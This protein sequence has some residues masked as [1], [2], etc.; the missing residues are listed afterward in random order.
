MLKI[1]EVSKNEF[2][3]KN[4]RSWDPELI[5]N[6]TISNVELNEIAP[7]K[8]KA[9]EGSSKGSTRAQEGSSKGSTRVQEG[10]SK[11]STRVQQYVDL[12]PAI[13]L[14]TP[15]AEEQTHLENKRKLIEK[16]SPN[17]SN[18]LTLIV[19]ICAQNGT[20]STG[21]ICSKE[22][23]SYLGIPRNSRETTIKRL[24]KKDLIFREK[25]KK[26]I[27]ATLNISITNEVKN[28]FLNLLKFKSEYSILLDD[29]SS[30]QRVQQGF[31]NPISSSSSNSSTTIPNDWQ[32]IDCSHLAQAFSKLTTSG[33]FFTKGSLNAIYKKAGE[34]LT[35]EQVQ[36]SIDQFAYGLEYFKDT[37]PY[38]SMK[39]P[40]ACLVDWLKNGDVFIE[41][42]YLTPEEQTLKIVYDNLLEKFESE[43]K[44]YFLTWLNHDRHKKY[45]EIEKTM[46]STEFYDD[47]IFEEKAS[48]I[49]INQI[50]PQ[51]RKE[52]AQKM[53][54]DNN[55]EL[56]EKFEIINGA[57]AEQESES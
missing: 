17:E 29:N 52:L 31:K 27:H 46:G 55:L 38:A 42:R 44:E 20:L 1:D 43:K 36:N 2:K 26:G 30:I 48:D 45:D 54:G 56:I 37:E 53:L 13:P 28:I 10:S 25:G 12:E 47:R 51:K 7:N 3:K 33:Q 16:L 40:G 23:D 11:G 9:Q 22:I 19:N 8:P 50:W 57:V 15:K 4:Y 32:K 41:P 35:A 24:K 21:D 18:F 49:F 39:K 5:K 14:K 6:L 34:K